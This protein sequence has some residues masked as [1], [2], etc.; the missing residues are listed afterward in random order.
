MSS[1]I[2]SAESLNPKDLRTAGVPA[3]FNG[4]KAADSGGPRALG[5]AAVG[6]AELELRSWYESQGGIGKGFGPGGL[7]GNG[8]KAAKA[9]AKQEAIEVMRVK[10]ATL[11]VSTR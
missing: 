3:V 7:G 5:R 6:E 2:L 9:F 4:D 10:T 11:C 8:M 1:L